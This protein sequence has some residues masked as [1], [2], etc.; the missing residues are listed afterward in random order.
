MAIWRGLLF[1]G[2]MVNRQRIDV[3]LVREEHNATYAESK[4]AL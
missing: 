3:L 4:N 1:I 2:R